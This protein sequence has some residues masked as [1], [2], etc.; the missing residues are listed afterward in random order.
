MFKKLT[1]L[2][3]AYKEKAKEFKDLSTEQKEHFK[4][5]TLIGWKTYLYPNYKKTTAWY[6]ITFV[7]VFLLAAYGIWSN[8][9]T[10]SV[11]VI[12]AAGVYYTIHAQENPI[13]E[14]KISDIGLKVGARFYPYTDIAT[15]WLDYNPPYASDLHLVLKNKHKQDITIQF[16]KID[17][18]IIRKALGAYL[19]EWEER[20]KNLGESITNLFGL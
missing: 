15:F 20:E 6:L 5:R 8:A 9:W 3:K 1:D 19:P 13:I 10:F 16:H 7:I 14:V 11:V 4:T 17:P 2:G 18:A 12:I